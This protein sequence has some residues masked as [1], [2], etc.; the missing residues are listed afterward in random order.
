MAESR[1][2]PYP[3][4]K[5]QVPFGEVVT[6]TLQVTIYAG[7]DRGSDDNVE[8]VFDIGLLDECDDGIEKNYIGEQG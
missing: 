8:N 7:Q 1:L 4:A 3:Q 5:V 2:R 6:P